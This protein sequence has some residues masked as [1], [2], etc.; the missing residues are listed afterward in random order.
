MRIRERDLQYLVDRINTAKG[1][2]LDPYNREE[3]GCHPNAGVYHLDYSYGGV[4]LVQMSETEGCTGI[5]DVTCGIDTKR[6]LHGK[7]LS[8]L[9]GMEIA[10]HELV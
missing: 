9:A 6:I 3:S 7:L 4:K 8:I 2:P 5:S 1:L 10:S